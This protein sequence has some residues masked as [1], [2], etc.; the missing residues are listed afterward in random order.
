MRMHTHTHTHNT[1]SLRAYSH[2][3]TELA[4][5]SAPGS[6]SAFQNGIPRWCAAHSRVSLRQ[7]A[8]LEHEE[9]DASA[10]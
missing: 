6:L 2:P 3:L 5:V 4:P 10:A 8:F 7:P 1:H 9:A